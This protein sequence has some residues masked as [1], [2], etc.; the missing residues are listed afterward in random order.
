MRD[1]PTS[2]REFLAA[3]LA[4]GSCGLAPLPE[5]AH[6]QDRPADLPPAD[7]DCPRCLGM[8]LI[9]LKNPT[10][11]VFISGQGPFKPEDAV[12]GE[13]CPECL[14]T[15]DKNLLVE[16]AK[17]DHATIEENHRQ[18][19]GRLSGR[20]LLLQTRHATIHAQLRP[21]DARKAGQ[22]VEA[23]T[24]HLQKVT[25]SLRLTPTRPVNYLQ[26]LLW[27][28]AAYDQFRKAM[29]KLYPTEQLGENWLPARDANSYDH[30]LIAHC[31]L[32][33]LTLRELPPEYHSLKFAATRQI[34]V[35]TEWQA[36]LWLMEGFGAYTQD[37]I[38]KD[39]RVST[40]Y[41]NDRGPGKPFTLQDAR[42]QHVAG[43]TRPW[44]EI[45]PRELREFEKA[46]YTQVLGMVAFLMSREPRQILELVRLIREGSPAEN[47]L[48]EAY[49]QSVA[50]LDEA[51]GKW[52]SG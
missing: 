44:E 34:Q 2:R 13:L 4:L 39:V 41:V 33:P 19:Q 11:Y 3:G 17:S 16:W 29:E 40:V 46:D 21:A 52:L 30:F 8:G 50:E 28:R 26:T 15:A 42:K 31:Y 25:D 1:F 51:C 6:A 14:S 32:T 43:Q 12:A 7:V 36:P 20:L 48:S 47:A 49:G 23:L 35:A 18:W 27:N 38:L 45:L 24:L 22:A 37:A 10:P 5:T 9:P